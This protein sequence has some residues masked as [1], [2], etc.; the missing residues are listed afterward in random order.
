MSG[1]LAY[2]GG[3]G[4][5]VRFWMDKWCGDEPLCESFPSLFTISSYKEAWV[6]DVW[7]LDGDGDGWT[8]LF[9]RAFNDWELELV[10][11]FLEKIQAFK[12]HRDAE[13]RVIWTI[14]RY[15]TFSVKPLY[16]ILGPEVSPLFPSG[17]IWKSS[18]PPKV[19]FFAWEASWGKVLNLD[20]LQRREHFLVN[21]CFLCL[22]KVEMIDHLLLHSAKTQVLWNHLFSL[23][24]VSWILSCSI[25]ETLL[26]W[27]GSFVG[28]ARK[29]ASQVPPLCI[30]WTMWKERNLIAFDNEEL[31]IQ[32]LKNSF[33][34]NL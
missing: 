27:H 22:S 8:P 10:E 13:D 25:K 31:S 28:K 14:S 20:Q 16:S 5:R 15:G 9:S 17:S 1:R 2:Q 12:V 19:A 33:V 24:G 18:V 4:Q 29:K 23:F 26:G 34:C 11:H 30:F 3:N 32:R 21:R 7:N 6:A